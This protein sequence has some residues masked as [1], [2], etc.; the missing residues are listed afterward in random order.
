MT[1]KETGTIVS[2]AG[3]KGL[4]FLDEAETANR[5]AAQLRAGGADAIVVLLHQ[6]GRTSGGYNDKSCP[7]LSGDIAPILQRLDPA[8]DVV[9]SGHTHQAYVCEVPRLGQAPLLL[10]SAGR[11]GTLITEVRLSFDR[12][13]RLSGRRADNVVV[14]NEGFTTGGEQVPPTNSLPRFAA[15][16]RTVALVGRYAAAAAPLAARVVGSLA[17]PVTTARNE[18]GEQTAGY[19]V[20]DAQLAAGRGQ[21]A[22]VAF[23]N[24]GGVRADL[25]PGA[26]G[27]VTYGQAFAVQPFGNEVVVMTLTGGQLK[28][29]LEQQFASGTNTPAQ[30]KFLLPSEGFEF[31]YDLARAA[32]QRVVAMRLGGR[33]IDPAQRYRVATN[34][35]LATGGDNFTVFVQGGETVSVGLDLDALE[36]HLARGAA[37]PRL[38]RIR[39][40]GR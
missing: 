11:Y 27:A 26:S 8:I 3:V 40:A 15:D 9:I 20:A 29:L 14:Q 38:G 28:A 2:P 36:G 19:L 33:P 6:G 35:F 10:T 22:Q 5:L 39:N 30:P 37:V 17:G 13:G 31:T 34:T 21:G 24:Q 12:A 23:V 16:P 7:E 1:L 25:V 4:T 32:G 18:A